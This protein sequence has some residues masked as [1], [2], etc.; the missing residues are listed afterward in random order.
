MPFLQVPLFESSTHALPVLMLAW[1]SRHT[2]TP[3]AFQA[4]CAHL[5]WKKVALGTCSPFWAPAQCTFKWE[6]AFHLLSIDARSCRERGGIEC[7]FTFLEHLHQAHG[8][9]LGIQC[10]V[11][12]NSCFSRYIAAKE[13]VA[14]GHAPLSFLCNIPPPPPF[15]F[16]MPQGA[17]TPLAL[18]EQPSI[19]AESLNWL[20]W[21]PT[22][23]HS[24]QHPHASSIL[25]TCFEFA[26]TTTTGMPPQRRMKDRVTEPAT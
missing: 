11:A 10:C 26:V 5:H 25:H 7:T 2:C 3:Y 1:D 20:G 6:Q 17:I 15:D 22:Q 19:S 8:G 4:C 24:Y 9:E 14:S 12:P 13:A 23:T 16:N 21:P 18:K